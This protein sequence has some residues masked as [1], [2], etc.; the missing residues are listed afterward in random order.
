MSQILGQKLPIHKKRH[1]TLKSIGLKD[2]KN[3][4]RLTPKF[5][6]PAHRLLINSLKLVY[7]FLLE[8]KFGGNP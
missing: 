1:I 8:T 2:S 5:L 6:G 3:F 7:H 4:T